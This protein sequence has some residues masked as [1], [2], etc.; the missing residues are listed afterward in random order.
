MKLAMTAAALAGLSLFGLSGSL[1]AQAAEF[2]IGPGGVHVERDHR[3]DHRYDRAQ[4]RT[5]IDHRT[6]RWGDDVTVRRRV[7]D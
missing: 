1:P 5:I 7:C 2:E 6:N 4:C 3:W